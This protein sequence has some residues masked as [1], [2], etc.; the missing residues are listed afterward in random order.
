MMK[1]V[2]QGKETLG[3]GLPFTLCAFP[4]QRQW[5]ML[6]EGNIKVQDSA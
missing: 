4:P 2:V 3:H 1:G 6:I 5:E